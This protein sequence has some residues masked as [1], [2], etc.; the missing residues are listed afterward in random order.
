MPLTIQIRLTFSDEQL[1]AIAKKLGRPE[2]TT[3]TK[4]EVTS[5]VLAATRAHLIA[6]TGGLEAPKQI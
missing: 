1:T 3:A 5:E 4:A 6:M 2:G